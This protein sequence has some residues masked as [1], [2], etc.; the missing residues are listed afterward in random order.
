MPER[1]KLGEILLEAGAITEKQ[2]REALE[3][4]RKYGGKLGE[5]L[6]DR[7]YISERAYL[8]ALSQQLKIPAIDFTKSTI[9]EQVIH[10]VPQEIQERH[11]VFPVATKRT[12]RGNVLVLAMG[13]PTNVEVQD[14]IRFMTGYHIEPVIALESVIRQVIRDYWYRQEGKGSYRYEPDVDLSGWEPRPMEISETDER[15]IPRERMIDF[16]KEK[17]EKISEENLTSVRARPSREL[18]ALLRLLAKKGII[19]EQEYLEELKKIK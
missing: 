7:R 12:A 3:D 17:E 18:L 6:I 11:N 8:R 15:F 2:L 19:T 10:M 4:Q 9:P 5:I 13:D 16:E 14:E 1:K